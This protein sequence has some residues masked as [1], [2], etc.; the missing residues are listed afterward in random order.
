M[1]YVAIPRRRVEPFMY[2]LFYFENISYHLIGY[3][4]KIRMNGDDYGLNRVLY[5]L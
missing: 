5:K 2:M 1:D 4:V 3:N